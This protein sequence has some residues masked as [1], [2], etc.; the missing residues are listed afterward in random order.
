M[1]PGANPI[2]EFKQSKHGDPLRVREDLPRL[3]SQGWEKLSASDKEL[4][5]WVGV[6]FRK[7]TPGKFMMRI[8]MPNG[9]ATSKQ[10]AA[11]SDVSSRLGNGTLDI[12][13]RQQIELRGYCL[14]SVPEIFERLR[15][16]DLT[17]LQTGQDNVR[18]LNGCPLA[19]VNPNE[20]L[21]A[22]PILFGLDRTIVGG[23]QGNPEFANL[24]RKIN[25]VVTG[26]VE[27]CTHS[28]SQDISLVPATKYIHGTLY[29]GFHVLVGGKMGSGGFTIASNLGWFLESDQAEEVVLQIIKIFRDEGERGS[30]T[31]CRLAFLL[32]DWGLDRFRDELIKRLGWQPTPEGKDARN[33]GH[34]DHF[35]VHQQ[36]QPGLY[37]VGLR[38][39][40]GR[41]SH[42]S[43]RELAR[44]AD[45]YG[46][47]A[48][49]LTT[50]QDAILI[51]VPEHRLDDLLAEPLL[52]ELSPEPS[53]FFRGMVSCTGTDYCN[54]AQI[55]TKGR[56]MEVST[57]LEKQL[58]P[59]GKPITIHWSG[60][61]AG[62]GNHL[63][64]DIGLRGMRVN[65]DGKSVE[66]VAVYVGGR[67]GPQARAGTQI[68][69]LVP[70]D[71]ALPDVLANVVKHLSMFKRVQAQ[72]TVRDRILMV[73]AEM[74]E[75]DFET[76]EI[77]R[78]AA[79]SL[80][81]L[82]ENAPVPKLIVAN[83]P[84]KK[85][86]QVKVCGLDD[87]K[88]GT[89]YPA[90][91]QGKSLALFREGIDRIFAIDAV[92]PHAAGPL[93]EGRMEN[94]EV[95]CPL[96]DYRFDLKTGKCSTDPEFA[97]KTYPVVV[98]E[99]QVWVEIHA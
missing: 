28:E 40:V 69:D 53:R 52:K 29:T 72:P 68:M 64:A 30:R 37:S 3:T 23:N 19:G 36:K 73:P 87:L 49:R 66:A 2:E 7:P 86:V 58:G 84:S 22:S 98:E 26:C 89:G 57:A 31:K 60:C 34:N 9:F 38:V 71:E 8:R 24:P 33:E 5:K 79:V 43:L 51:N 32:E 20:L 55:D 63:A 4:L 83:V 1:R 81:E 13:T 74:P 92:C 90:V 42:E 6:F 18:N 78:P 10:L 67:T 77:E 94:C 59:D 80:S 50:G 99:N 61:P 46:N 97:V 44:I 39:N 41:I 85:A 14:E 47:G 15:G 35:G 93:E 21:D 56:A 45:V 11:I 70:C 88:P 17:S 25:I 96:H 62:C 12:T 48:V 76:D 91:V 16:V 65:V 75:E 27:N 95:I 82:K 54:I